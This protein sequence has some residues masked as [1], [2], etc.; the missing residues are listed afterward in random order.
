[1]M[2]EAAYLLSKLY[3]RGLVRPALN[4]GQEGRPLVTKN[5]VKAA[6]WTTVAADITRKK[7]KSQRLINYYSRK[8][9][10]RLASS[11]AQ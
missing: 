1:M 5:A 9:E 3:S 6:V 11:D 2:A 10:R 8:L 4:P 7:S